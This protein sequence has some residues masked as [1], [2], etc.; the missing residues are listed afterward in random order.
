[1]KR[2]L[3]ASIA[4]AGGLS[5]VLGLPTYEQ[6]A[7]TTG[8]ALYGNVNTNTGET[9]ADW[10]PIAPGNSAYDASVQDNLNMSYSSLP[11]N[12]PGPSGTMAN[13]DIFNAS[14]DNGNAAC[15]LFS[16]SILPPATGAQPIFI[17][18]FVQV[19]NTNGMNASMSSGGLVPASQTNL[20]GAAPTSFYG[21]RLE[22]TGS[23]RCGIS[24]CDSGTANNSFAT[25]YF[26]GAAPNYTTYFIVFEYQFVAPS[27]DDIFSMWINPAASTFGGT[28]GTPTKTKTSATAETLTDWSGFFLL[29]RSGNS[30]QSGI[31]MSDLRIGTNWAYV[32]GGAQFISYAPASTNISTGQTLV[33]NSTAVAGG[34]PVNYSWQT[35]NGTNSGAL[36]TGGRFSVGPTGALTISNVQPGDAGTYTLQVGT[37]VTTEN[38]VS[39]RTAQNDVTVTQA[40]PPSFTSENV[41]GIGSGQFQMN[42]HRFGR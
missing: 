14:G 4:L 3:M 29:A 33:L 39:A 23:A 15:L 18:F 24:A 27:R 20:A 6:F 5:P 37:P 8:S 9:W 40:T 31:N 19:P 30:P 38:S 7:Y 28:P 26:N 25:S 22:N 36:I 21:V 35:N 41:S 34:V 10:T 17:S 42:F 16:Q 32:T 1:M 11:T 12:F 2:I 13:F